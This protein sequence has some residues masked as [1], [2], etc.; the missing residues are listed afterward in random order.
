MKLH[1]AATAP[2]LLQKVSQAEKSH[3]SLWLRTLNSPP[4][5]DSY[6][7]REVGFA[8]LPMGGLGW[9][10]TCSGPHLSP[11]QVLLEWLSTPA[12]GSGG[13]RTSNTGSPESRRNGRW[14]G[15]PSQTSPPSTYF[16][17]SKHLIIREVPS[18]AQQVPKSTFA[19]YLAREH[20][21]TLWT[22]DQSAICSN[23][24]LLSWAVLKTGIYLNVHSLIS[25]A[26]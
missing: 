21:L 11:L 19:N 24:L 14:V 1:F 13:S 7:K 25:C 4:M 15:V 8:S 9:V 26:I 20:L 12:S 10:L 5:Q 22:E 2:C 3:S 16:P 17:S 6:Q 18:G 23:L